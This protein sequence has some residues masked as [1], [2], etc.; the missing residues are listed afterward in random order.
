M[1]ST[2]TLTLKLELVSDIPAY[3]LA[4]LLKSLQ[5]IY[6]YNLWLDLAESRT[7]PGPF[8]DEYVP[9]GSEEM[10]VEALEIGTPNWIK[11]R[12]LKN[13]ML[14]VAALIAALST[15]PQAVMDVVKASVEIEKMK[16]EIAVIEQDLV[17]KQQEYIAK[18]LDLEER[19]KELSMQG[20][21]SQKA[22]KHKI[23]SIPKVLQ[24]LAIGTSLVE[25]GSFGLE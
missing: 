3:K 11:L 25:P 9:T 24:K 18:R 10:W 19:V 20:K 4:A 2:D 7:L 15:G 21:V 16:A 22:L 1:D 8:P 5:K 12:G 13:Q 6:F 23:E 14:A 17:L